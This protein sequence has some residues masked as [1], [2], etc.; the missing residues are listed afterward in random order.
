MIYRQLGTSD[1][2][3]SAIIFG[4][5]AIGGWW[6]GGT[7]DKNALEAIHEAFDLG[8]NCIDTAP[9]YGFGH[10]EQLVAKVI[11]G[12][13]SKVIL[14]TKC[15]LRWD[16]EEG[17]F[18]FDA[19]DEVGGRFKVHRNLRYGSILEECN[20]SLKRLGTDYIDLYQCHWPDATTDLGETMDALLEL[21]TQGKIRVF[22]VTNFSVDMMKT[23]LKKG[24]LAS[25][26]PKYSLLSRH[27]ESDVLPFCR[28]EGIGILAYSPMEHGLLTGKF[29]PDHKFPPG[30]ERARQPWFQVE[31]RERVHKAIESV[32]PIAQALGVTAGQ[33]AVNWI[34]SQPGVTSTIVGARNAAQV[35]ENA[36]AADFM[37][38]SD[39]IQSIR[40]EFDA[41][42]DPV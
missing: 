7:D 33:L 27:I 22:G 25:L 8:I 32:R 31:N 5:W 18:F 35:R 6:W 14:A 37:L 1:L 3:V 23:C 19:T 36:Q 4:A 38:S 39:Q 10:S 41:I 9:Q 29:T 11:K 20:R 24:K 21:Q 2:K 13:R 26:Q 17:D 16:L 15:G 12:R 34:L 42:G 28:S 40:R 30:D